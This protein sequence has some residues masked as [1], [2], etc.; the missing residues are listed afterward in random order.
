MNILVEIKSS[1]TTCKIYDFEYV[2]YTIF[3]G[4]YKASCQ[5]AK[6]K[7]LEQI[8][9][10]KSHDHCLLNDGNLDIIIKNEMLDDKIIDVAMKSVIQNN[11]LLH[12]QSCNRNNELLEYSNM[13]TTHIHYN[14]MGHWITSSSIGNRIILYDIMN[15][16][17]SDDILNQVTALYSQDSKSVP[18]MEQ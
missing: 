18:P 13:E 12:I 10:C 14:G 4:L 16:Q 6:L 11:P 3:Q 7:K 9:D 8:R 2:P 17:P 5:Q 15:L 1:T